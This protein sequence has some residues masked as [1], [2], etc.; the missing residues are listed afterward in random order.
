MQLVTTEEESSV[1]SGPKHAQQPTAKEW[2]QK[3]DL[4]A[5][6]GP[7]Q[8]SPESSWPPSRGDSTGKPGLSWR[9]H[10]LVQE[11]TWE[12]PEL[13]EWLVP[14]SEFASRCQMGSLRPPTQRHFGHS[15]LLCS[16]CP[17][18]LGGDPASRSQNLSLLGA[19][20]CDGRITSMI[21]FKL[22][23]ALRS[24]C[25]HDPRVTDEKHQAE[26]V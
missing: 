4:L 18:P 15:F 26:Q 23:T 13:S 14:L 21:S 3:L 8:L 24:T 5:E 1:K 2:G 16:Y 10:R 7:K 12:I 22:H 19:G 11:W 6:P 25:H 9:R 17:Q 20:H